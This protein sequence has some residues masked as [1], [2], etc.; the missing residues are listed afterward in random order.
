M[1]DAPRPGWTQDEDG[2]WRAPAPPPAK[3]R[4]VDP[5]VIIVVALVLVVGIAVVL[6]LAAAFGGKT[7]AAPPP[8]GASI[9]A[10]ATTEAPSTTAT[11]PAN[12]P[13]TTAPAPSPAKSA[14]DL[15]ASV[16]LRWVTGPV[17]A[18][19]TDDPSVLSQATASYLTPGSSQVSVTVYVADPAQS[20]DFAKKLAA[21]DGDGFLG[22]HCSDGL[23]WQQVKVK[24]GTD[25]VGPTE[26]QSQVVIGKALCP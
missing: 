15:L 12:R 24:D 26:Q 1:G 2:N 9:V 13:P 10:P 4:S 3:S 20:H 6:G 22:G 19:P 17:P 11:V 23:L 8:A 16:P 14:A 25:D 21:E 18:N 7:T 5:F